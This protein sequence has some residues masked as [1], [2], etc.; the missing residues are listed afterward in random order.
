MGVL[1]VE[2]QETRGGGGF[3]YVPF[4]ELSVWRGTLHSWSKSA[5]H[6]CTHPQLAIMA[7]KR[8]AKKTRY[9]A[10]GNAMHAVPVVRAQRYPS[11]DFFSGRGEHPFA[12]LYTW[13]VCRD[14]C[15]K[16]GIN[17]EERIT[18]QMVYCVVQIQQPIN[19]RI[20]L[21]TPKLQN[22]PM[23][24]EIQGTSVARGA[25]MRCKKAFPWSIK[26]SGGNLKRCLAIF[27]GIHMVSQGFVLNLLSV[28][29]GPSRLPLEN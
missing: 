1:P 18:R 26:L 2:E 3:T 22:P 8:H 20:K 29:F 14:V 4:K 16:L 19:K 23:N 24:R 15:H 12:A 7:N 10:M 11:G 6:S 25:R 13:A 21:N 28:A 27:L 5:A 9:D 17:W